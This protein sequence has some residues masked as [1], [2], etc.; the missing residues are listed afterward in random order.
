MADGFRETD[1]FDIVLDDL[2]RVTTGG[3]FSLI[4]HYSP[5]MVAE[6]AMGADDPHVIAER[7]GVGA[8]DYEHLASQDWFARLVAQKRHEFHDTGMLFVAKAGMMAEALLTRLFQQSM[9]GVIAAPLTVEVAKQLTD[10]GRLKPQPQGSTPGSAGAPF[11]INI[12][13]N[14]SDVVTT[15]PALVPAPAQ[16]SVSSAG[17]DSVAVPSAP[18]T[19]A[20]PGDALA[21][22]AAMTLDFGKVGPKPAHISNLRTPDFDLRPNPR[23]SQ[24]PSLGVQTA[25]LPP[26]ATSR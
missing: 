5:E 26:A 25:P 12:Q 24:V 15:R 22:G 20:E 19:P 23:A 4:L 18:T 11:Q 6:L 2:A 10:I 17:P 1:E 14:G 16:P 21:A 13:V 9:A 3:E 8:D 7:Y